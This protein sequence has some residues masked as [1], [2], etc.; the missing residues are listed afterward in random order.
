[1]DRI[2]YIC[3]KFPNKSHHFAKVFLNS[4]FPPSFFYLVSSNLSNLS[5]RAKG[6]IRCKKIIRIESCFP[7]FHSE[8]PYSGHLRLVSSG[9]V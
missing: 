9:F 3:M 5:N 8:A 4:P 1:M 6:S 7:A 2:H